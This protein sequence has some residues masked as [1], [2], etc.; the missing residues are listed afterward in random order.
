MRDYYEILGVDKN[1]S[2]EEIKSEYRKLAKK[3]HPDLNQGDEEAAEKFK[4]ATAAYE[5]LG[6]EEMRARYDR[7]GHAGVDP[8]SAAGDFSNIN[9]DDLFSDLFGSDIFSDFFGGGQ[10]SRQRYN[11][12]I[13]G[14][15]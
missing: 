7:Y 4:E 5:V 2:I 1:A 11:G 3:Y 6:D 13:P 14:M 12:P 9:F 15:I 8:N 10:R